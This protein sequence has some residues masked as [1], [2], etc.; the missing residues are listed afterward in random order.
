[1]GLVLGFGLGAACRFLRIPVPG[2][3]KLL[4][5]LLVAAITAGFVLA[6]ALFP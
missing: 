1:M 5:A 6:G 3:Q 2:P 4:G